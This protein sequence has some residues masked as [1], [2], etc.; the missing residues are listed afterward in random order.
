MNLSSLTNHGP[1]LIS[2]SFDKSLAA[3]LDGGGLKGP[4]MERPRLLI[5]EFDAFRESPTFHNSPIRYL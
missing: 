3:M 4:L 1:L 2:K 5:Y